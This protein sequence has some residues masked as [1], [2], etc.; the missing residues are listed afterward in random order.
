MD[1]RKSLVESVLKGAERMPLNQERKLFLGYE[2]SDVIISYDRASLHSKETLKEVENIIGQKRNLKL[3]CNGTNSPE[4]N[5]KYIQ[6]AS[7]HQQS[8]SIV[9]DEEFEGD[10]GLVIIQSSSLQ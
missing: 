5:M 3:I 8:F 1:E 9:T 6:L 10:V 4:L 2:R 7:R